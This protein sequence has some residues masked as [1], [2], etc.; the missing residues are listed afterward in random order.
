M[1]RSD[2]TTSPV[3]IMHVVKPMNSACERPE[4]VLETE[5]RVADTYRSY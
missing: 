2:R 1:F 4:H 3:L 5:V